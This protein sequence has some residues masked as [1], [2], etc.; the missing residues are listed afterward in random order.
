MP[1]KATVYCDTDYAGCIETRKSTTS[2]AVRFGRHT[3]RTNSNTQHDVSLSS[4]ESEFYGLIKA[5]SAALGIQA[6]L[7]DLGVETQA[8]ELRTDSTAAKAIASR[9]GLGKTRHIAVR[10]LWIQQRVSRRD[11]TIEKEPTLTNVSDI[12]TK[13]LT[14]DRVLKLIDGLNAYYADGRPR[15]APELPQQAEGTAQSAEDTHGGQ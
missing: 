13:S 12:G 11:V 9:R 8:P 5:S 14:E 3:L 1:A 15:L 10:F 4:G 2:I 6:M 7:G